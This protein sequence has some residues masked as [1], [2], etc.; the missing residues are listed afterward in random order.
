[1]Q[2]DTDNPVDPATLG[3]TPIRTWVLRSDE[4]GEAQLRDSY[5]VSGDEFWLDAQRDPAI[6]IGTITIQETKAPE[7]YVIDPTVRV[8]SVK[9]DD[10]LEDEHVYNTSVI[11]NKEFKAYIKIVKVDKDSQKPILNNAATFK[12]WSYDNNAY[13]SFNNVSEFSTDNNGVLTTPGTLNCGNYRIDEIKN[14]EGYYSETAAGV[15]LTIS[16][17]ANYEKHYDA[18]G[19]VITDMGTFVV[20]KDNSSTKGYIEI[21]KKAEKLTWDKDNEKYVSTFE[22]K[23]GVVFDVY[24]NADIYSPDGQ[25]SIVYK[26]GERV[27]QITTNTSG[28]ARTGELYLGKYRVVEHIPNGYVSVK[29]QTVTLSLNSNKN[30]INQGGSTKKLVYETLDFNNIQQRTQIKVYKTDE[31]KMI[32]LEGAEFEL[33]EYDDKFTRQDYLDKGVK[34]SS[35]VTDENGELIFDGYFPLGEYAIIETKAPVGYEAEF[36]EHIIKA[37]YDDTAV[38]YILVEDTFI[39]T[40]IKG[41][42]EINKEAEKLTW[43]KESGKY[44]STYE[45][46]A[47]VKFDIFADED[48]Y[49]SFGEGNLVYKQGELVDTITTD[50][51]GYAKSIELY[52]GKYRVKESV[53]DGYVAVKDQ[54]V[55][56]SLDSELKEITEESGRVKKLVYETLDLKNLMQQAQIK[57]YKTDKDKIFYLEG[58]EYNLYEYNDTFLTVQDYLD[59]GVKVSSG[60]TDSNGELIFDGFFPLGEYVAVEITAPVGYI[61]DEQIHRLSALYDDNAIEYIAVNDSYIND[62]VKA[63]VTLTKRDM[64]DKEKTLEGVKFNLYKVVSDESVKFSEESHYIESFKELSADEQTKINSF[65]VNS[66]DMFIGEFVTDENGQIHIDNLVYGEYYFIETETLYRYNINDVPQNFFIDDNGAVYE[67]EM[68]NDGRIGRLTVNGV[69]KPGY[70]GGVLTGDSVPVKM[71]FV[72]AALSLIG[73]V[74]IIIKRRRYAK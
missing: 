18:N 25:K 64:Q 40:S 29:D 58:A 3:Y 66:E 23:A 17:T 65:K 53:P 15:N 37:E 52:L 35:G 71:L 74:V 33:Y 61:T 47:D 60:I 57:V 48:I 22:N 38:E 42:I 9:N 6:P 54:T 63:S 34:V 16:T 39:D 20:T 24:A 14:P 8:Q 11:P 68:Y 36:K 32:Y 1:M 59:K 69:Q 43:D 19:N 44:V 4:Y 10:D 46:K 27:A 56:L 72:L 73:I 13:V 67:Y 12:I 50:E 45:P 26:K 28:Y 62:S 30:D 7:G 51:H 2:Q 49:T 21:N 5:K 55:T 41:Y 31:S 70:G